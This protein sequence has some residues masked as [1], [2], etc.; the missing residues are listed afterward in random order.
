MAESDYLRKVL[1]IFVVTVIISTTIITILVSNLMEP[2]STI[3]TTTETTQTEPPTQAIQLPHYPL[4]FLENFSHFT[5]YETEHE[6]DAPQYSLDAGLS[7]ILNLFQFSEL[8]GWNA[9]VESKIEEGY[10]A[11]VQGLPYQQFSELYEANYWRSIPSFVTADSMYH[12]FH[13]L[14]DYTLRTMETD[15]LT[16]YLDLLINHLLDNSLS[17][18]KNLEEGFWRDSARLNVAFFSVAKLVLHPDWSAPD[19]VLEEV[20]TAVG[21]IETALGFSRAWFMDQLEDFS[22]FI[23]RGHYTRSPELENYF[24][25]MMWLGRTQ[26]RLHPADDWRTDAENAQKGLT[27][28]AQA[29][30]TSLALKDSSQYLIDEDG[31]VLWNYIY[32]PT[33]FFVGESDDLT[34]LEYLSAIDSV[35]GLGVSL[36][37]VQDLELLED[38]IQTAGEL[39]NPR[40]LSD[41]MWGSEEMET[42]TKGMSVMGQRYVPDSYIFWQLVYPNVGIARTLPT[43]LDVMSV[44]GSSRADE[45]LV[46]EHVH[47]NYTAQ[48]ARLKNEFDGLPFEQWIQNLYWLWLYSIKPMLDDVENGNPSFMS[49]GAWQ[50]KRLATALGTWTELRHDTVLYAKQSYTGVRGIPHPPTGYVEP[51]PRV[52]AR[53]ASLSKMLL[54]GLRGR[55]LISKPLEERLTSLHLVLLR[56]KAI[57]VKEL[58]GLAL[59]ETDISLTKDIGNVL[60]YL[61]GVED[62]IDRAALVVDVHTDPGPPGVVLEEATG[63]PLVVFVAVPYPNGSV[64]LTRGAIYSYYEFTQSLSDRLTDDMWWDLLDTGD[65]PDMPVWTLSFIIDFSTPESLH[66]ET[67]KLSIEEKVWRVITVE[68]IL[69][70]RNKANEAD[71]S[72]VKT[73]VSTSEP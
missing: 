58:S 42:V 68:I 57:S 59:N 32:Q 5:D 37:D 30:L 71:Q 7:N 23:P 66:Q 8:D 45:L 12:V 48:V 4:A 73:Y 38:F 25:A 34:P 18:Y 70:E 49:S 22:Q 52:Y 33:V 11:A 3:P 27:E 39:R 60:K 1:A 14:Y 17:Q 46:P 35:F 13:V 26:F 19:Y 24:K 67:T 53:L 40:I 6:F 20:N 56:L 21:L 2:G 41:F 69:P 54:D 72:C 64:Y 10:F 55:A 43:A 62:D 51:V 36:E 29:I 15:N 61:E 31:I 28:T 47:D 65:E 9:D 50:D 44:L 63:D 16:I